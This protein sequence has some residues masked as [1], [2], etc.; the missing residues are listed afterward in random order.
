M[1]FANGRI[2][3]RNLKMQWP[4]SRRE[5]QEQGARGILVLGIILDHLGLRA[6]LTNLLFA[7]IALHHAPASVTTE[8]KLPSG[9]LLLNRRKSFHLV[10]PSTILISFGV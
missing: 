2:G 4:S 9:Q 5:T 7:D 3:K 1:I 10:A 8:F 6:R